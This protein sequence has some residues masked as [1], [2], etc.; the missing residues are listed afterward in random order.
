[1]I[2]LQP[3]NTEV[4]IASDPGDKRGVSIRT[5]RSPI[6][7]PDVAEEPPRFGEVVAVGTKKGYTFSCA[8]GDMVLFGRYDGVEFSRDESQ[9]YMGQ[10]FVD[11]GKHLRLIRDELLLAKISGL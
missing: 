6:L 7:R 8:V 5:T 3:R 11:A 10:A 9:R 1:M 2:K 4:L